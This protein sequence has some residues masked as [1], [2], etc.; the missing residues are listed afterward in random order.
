VDDFVLDV[1]AGEV[2]SQARNIIWAAQDADSAL[3]SSRP[4][5]TD[6]VWRHLQTILVSAAN[7]SK[8]FWGSRGKFE[9]ERKP[10]RDRFEVKPDSPLRDTA[11]RNDFEHFDERLVNHFALGKPQIFIGRNI[12]SHSAVQV[13]NHPVS[14]RF[15]NYD[16][17]TGEVTF[18]EHSVSL[19]EIVEEAQRILRADREA[20]PSNAFSRS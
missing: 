3:K 17:Q 13:G 19:S 9:T 14:D 6:E 11:L 16:P 1:F 18:W 4:G 7:L 20:Q 15:Q 12:G 8:M 10:L 2:R 5:S